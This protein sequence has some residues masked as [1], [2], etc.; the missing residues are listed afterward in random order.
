[1]LHCYVDR[2]DTN[3][4]CGRNQDIHIRRWMQWH[5]NIHRS[6]CQKVGEVDSMM[7][8]SEDDG[9]FVLN[10]VYIIRMYIY[11]CL[12][13]GVYI[14][15]DQ[16]MYVP[17]IQMFKLYLYIISLFFF[18]K[19]KVYISAKRLGKDWGRR[20][21]KYFMYVKTKAWKKYVGCSIG[22]CM[23]RILEKAFPEAEY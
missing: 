14:H 17:V 16:I 13:M 10:C 15:N 18:N 9:S 6:I 12:Y 7:N 20:P 11:V 8:K 22:H 19:V 21:M 2:V 5:P 3:F 1:M 4:H 23:V